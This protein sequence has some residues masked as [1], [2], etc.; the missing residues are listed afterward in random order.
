MKNV[1][2]QNIFARTFILQKLEQAL[3]EPPFENIFLQRQLR[4]RIFPQFF[5]T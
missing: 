5:M 4:Y 2:N 1:S 3:A